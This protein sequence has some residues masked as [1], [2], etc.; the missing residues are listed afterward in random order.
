MTDDELRDR[1]G[2]TDPCPITVAVH[3]IDGPHARALLEG[4]MTTPVDDDRSLDG[5]TSADPAA[6]PDRL[7]QPARPM[8]RRWLPAALVGAAVAA[9][10]TGVVAVG[11][12]TG[13]D[14]QRQSRP[15]PAAKTQTSLKLPAG[16]AMSSCMIFDVKVLAEMPVAFGGTAAD[17][18][19]SS[20]VIDVD[21]WYRGGSAQQVVVSIPPENTSAALDGVDF[22]KGQR[23]LVTATDGMVNGCG[24][25]GPA[26]PELETAFRQAFG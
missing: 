4:I 21:R 17:V 7:G 2:R 1:L 19:S 18:T 14:T 12:L 26:T 20:V 10:V 15:A 11:A 25:S 3:R 6:G 23:Y 5:D 8:R 16:S 9:A 24:F 13:D 22:V